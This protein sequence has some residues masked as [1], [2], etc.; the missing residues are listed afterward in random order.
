MQLG[1]RKDNMFKKIIRRLLSKGNLLTL[2][3]LSYSKV[4][5][6]SPIEVLEPVDVPGG[7]T[8]EELCVIVGIVKQIDNPRIFEFGSFRGRTCI[9]LLNNVPDAQVT[10][11]DL[12]LDFDA[13]SGEQMHWIAKDKET[14]LNYE[15]GVFFKKYADLS[16]SVE[17]LFGDSMTFDFS[18]YHRQFDFVFIDANHSYQNVINDSEVARQLIK[19]EGGIILWHDYSEHPELAGLVKALHLI[20][21]KQRLNIKQ[22]KR[23]KFAYLKLEKQGAFS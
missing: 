23:T 2:P 18:K 16:K 6:N 1:H 4:I 21:D 20:R 13:S 10:T 19:P 17:R 7:L 15:R 12:P 5:S 14:V 11:I 9:N 3:R 8:L 22:I